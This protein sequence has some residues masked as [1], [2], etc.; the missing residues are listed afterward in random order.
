ME[1]KKIKILAIDDNPE[2]LI[3]IEALVIDA[4][5]NVDVLLA[6]NA[7]DGLA[8]AASEN[9]D[10]ILLDIVLPDMDGFEVCEKL[11]SDDS[12]A[13]I[14]VVFITAYLNDKQSRIKGF[15]VG[16]EAFLVRPFDKDELLTLIRA[17]LKRKTATEHRINES[18]HLSTQI[19]EQAL[20]L[21]STYKATLNLMEDLKAENEV[22]RNTEDALKAS[23]ALYH[24]ILDASPDNITV[25]GLDGKIQMISSNGL[26]LIG[27]SDNE[28]IGRYL[29]EF[30][31][32]EDNER[33]IKNIEGMFNG[34]FNGPE[35][36]R[37]IQANGNIIETEINAE[38]VTDEFGNPTRI[39]F[40]VRDITERIRNQRALRESEEKYRTLVQYSSDPIFSYNPDYT[41][42]YVNEKF[43]KTF[44]YT[45]DEIIGKT[46]DFLFDKIEAEKRKQS[47]KIVFETGL[48]NELEVKVTAVNGKDIYMITMLDPITD[49]DGNI[50]YVSCISKDITQRKEMEIS[51][52]QSEEKYRLIT[53]KISDVVWLMDLNGKSMYVSQSIQNF[54]GYTVDEYLQQSISDRFAP[55]SAAMALIMLSEEIDLNNKSNVIKKDFKK[56]IML[57]Y[58]CKDGK[59]KTGELLITPYFDNNDDLIGIHGVTRDITKRIEAENAL[60]ES[61][62]KYYNLY[63]LLRSMSDTMPDMIWAKDLEGKFLFANKAICTNLLIAI[64]TDEPIGKDD[65]YFVN[66]QR[67][68]H[69][70]NPD[71]HTFGESCVNSDEITRQ[72]M[73]KMQFDEFGNVKGE[74][75]YLDVHKAPLYNDNNELIGLVGSA[76]DVT[77]KKV[78]EEQL[79][80]TKQ[81]YETFFNTIDEFLFVLD[82]QGNIIHTNST[83]RERLEYNEDELLGKSVLEVHPADRREEAGRIVGEM[84]MGITEMCPVPLITKSGNQIPVE[85]RVSRGF[86]D[87]KPVIFGV[88]KDITNLVFSE[89][90]FSKL[91]HLNPS[92]A[93]LSD[94]KTGQYIEVNQAFYNLLGFDENEVI[95]KT[96]SYLGIF[97]EK[98]KS[99]L[100]SKLDSDG[101]VSN[102]EIDLIAKN[103][104]I[105]NVSISGQNIMVQNQIYRFTVVNDLTEQKKSQKALL[106]S[107]EKYRS[108]VENSPNGIAI[109]QDG[110]FVYVNATGLKLFGTAK[111]EEIIG[112]PV[113]SI[114]H[115]DSIDAVV[116][117]MSQVSS[118]GQVPPL[119]EKLIRNDG[120]IFYAE[121]TALGTT[122]NGKLAVQVIVN[123]IS[124]RK[125][126]DERLSESE[127]KFRDMANLLP[128]VVFEIDLDG[129]ITYVNQQAQNLFGYEMD[130]LI[131][132]NSILVHVPEEYER[133]KNG[134]LNRVAGNSV[135]NREFSMVRKDGTEFPALVFINPIIK[136]NLPVGIRGVIV[137]ITEQKKSEKNITHIARLYALQSQI[138]QAIVTSKNEK[139]LFETICK[140]AIQYGQFKMSWIGVYD[141]DKDKLMP[142]YHAGYNN[143]YL[144]SLNIIPGNLNTGRGP[145]GLAYYEDRV[146]FCNDIAND[147]MMIPWRDEALKR[148]YKSS[149][150]TPVSKKRKRY[151]T[152]TL[153]ATEKDFFQED[154]QKLL[155]EIGENISFAL[156]AFDSENER[157]LAEIALVES[158]S[159]YRNLM[160]NSPEGIT[161]YV[162]GK[163]A[164]INKE[165]LKLMRAK[166]KSEMLGKTIVD[167]I[168]P[169]NIELVLERM[170][171][172]AL[173]P[174]NSIFP[175]VE[176]IYIR[177]D[178]TEVFVEIKVMPIF[179]DGKPA[180]QLV[181]HDISDR[182][183]VEQALEQSRLELKTIYDNA[184]VMMCVVDEDRK[185]QFANNAFSTLTGIT[186]DIMKGASIG[187]GIG[188]I[189]S[190]NNTRGCGFGYSCRSC[191]LNATIQKTFKTGIGQSNV[192]YQS[193]L[194]FGGE[195]RLVSL[196]GSTALIRTG[197]SKNLLLCL[198]DISDRKRTEDALQ[199]SESLLRTFIDNSPFEIW[200]RDVNSIGIL[201]NKKLTD[202]YGSIIGHST[203][204]DPR[205]SADILALWERNNSR[206]FAGEIL[207]EE[208][209]L[210]VNGEPRIFQQIE[211]PI[212]SNENIIGI[213]GFNIDI[214]EKKL[215]EEKIRENNTRLELA[216]QISNMAWWEMDFETGLVRFGRHKSDML[217][218]PSDKF[219]TY[220]DF[221]DLVHP[222]DYEN[223]M[224]A[225]N[226]HIHGE[227]EKYEI[228]YR[229]LT[230]KGTYKWFYDIGSISKRDIN[231][232][233]L[234]VS[235]L[236]VDISYRKDAEKELADQKQF[237]EQ[238][239]M[240]SSLS[241]QI[242]DNDGWCER[243]N[244]K[245]SQLFGVE[246][247]YMEGKVYNIFK[248][249]EILRNGIDSKL[250]KVFEEA[251]TVEWEVLFDIG[252]AADSQSVKL[253]ERKKAWFSNWAYP[254]LDN[255]NNVSHVIIQH[256]DITDR[257]SAEQ[258]LSESQEQLKKFAAHLQN[259]REEERSNLAREIHDDLGQI[260]IAMK[261]DLGLLKQSTL[262]KLSQHESKNLETNFLELQKLVDNTLKSARRIMTD[263]RPEVLD[264]LG[265]IDTVTQYLKSFQER[266]KITCIFTNNTSDIQ[267]TSQQSVALYRI[268]QE[269][270]NNISKHAKATVV[271]IILDQHGDNLSIEITDNGIGFDMS[272]PKKTDSYGL[273]GMKERVFLLN[274]E[275]IINSE[276]TKG[277]TI[278]VVMPKN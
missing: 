67:N 132:K 145:T 157:K 116:K 197:V 119:E 32:S 89:E 3:I 202:H 234:T 108:L 173:A 49:L 55:E 66:R 172:V 74:F 35:E 126:A 218:F 176:E 136:N 104:D 240:Q 79:E 188:C 230:S 259:V 96:A 228:E 143:G 99:L 187:N 179:F 162:E 209:E 34:I 78:I 153:Y 114:V 224:N 12:L 41:Y 76:R 110:K 243:I 156:D 186:E 53:E 235:G 166:D 131:G 264:L 258:A 85:T 249:A 75:I 90:K 128:Q 33:A 77:A 221:M 277:T 142:L 86:W 182:K 36:Y 265:F 168:H 204:S 192:E 253:N 183:S 160:D 214:T 171:M 247:K 213:A 8:L 39:V 239:F 13:D 84:L 31:V 245:L 262:K 194:E 4:F 170:K 27:C 127:E 161:I 150:A 106:Q 91:F 25:T 140:V 147:E 227:K 44:G 211:F 22:R 82:E 267:L 54:T 273:L 48:K 190:L 40:A 50:M 65:F 24:S 125:L 111:A 174:I 178:G 37:I 238:M 175:A 191:S 26:K 144:E 122:F 236:V 117:R 38:F 98:N 254:I 215:A 278:K 135:D 58:R 43:A 184:P 256:S 210:A 129:T 244:P 9:P 219:N 123:D 130:E 220:I 255:N 263:L 177:L 20:R 152:F 164:Y 102:A 138:N 181:G 201:E 158:E 87:G 18:L 113:M 203:K 193:I 248:D 275:L 229:I 274:G 51:L 73:Q 134:I 57:D 28:V 88:T 71:W 226:I 14:P 272:D 59:I 80:Q 45:P 225:M 141:K 212:I 252:E 107:E 124:E 64:D 61:E 60:R 149:F 246:A 237:F 222:D 232:K 165:A 16:G 30:L 266:N 62:S 251:Q 271:N 109:Y 260:L 159:K 68:E 72:A 93:G 17:M 223:V 270:L 81:N 155:F 5:H 23:E 269:S 56:I 46:P 42:R 233:P 196:L 121:V 139:I 200:A 29:G 101:N 92:A 167:F 250:K 276:L 199:K 180:I 120:S 105:K 242:L 163:V 100:Y 7:T 103:G 10:V 94:I 47:V 148:G 115:P 151:A 146:V 206:A 257:K 207:D 208:F 261:I 198:I 95:G 6:K 63:S 21:D 189:N 1:T 70:D 112:K 241:T 137:D 118:G 15:E 205:V 195:R 217:G 268:V 169:D 2:N 154:E 231:G 83:V 216:M 97:D 185:I 52:R 133:V 11:K 69:P 19:N